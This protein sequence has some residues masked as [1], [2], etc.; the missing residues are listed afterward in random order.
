MS[1]TATVRPMRLSVQS[2]TSPMPPRPS[3]SP[4]W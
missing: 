4:I 2:R 3:T 1:L